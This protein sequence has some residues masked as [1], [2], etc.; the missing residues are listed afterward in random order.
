[1]ATNTTAPKSTAA[2]AEAPTEEF[3]SVE[4]SRVVSLIRA[5]LSTLVQDAKRKRPLYSK[6]SKKAAARRDAA[7]RALIEFAAHVDSLKQQ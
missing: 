1:M 7:F 3:D 6:S 2:A 5:E 4:L